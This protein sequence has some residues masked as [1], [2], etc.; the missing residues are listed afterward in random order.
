MDRVCN[1]GTIPYMETLLVSLTQASPMKYIYKYLKE[2]KMDYLNRSLVGTPTKTL[3]ML[4]LTPGSGG[5]PLGGHG[6]L[7]P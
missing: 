1:L 4:L 2:N 5:R 6:P 3:E 7:K